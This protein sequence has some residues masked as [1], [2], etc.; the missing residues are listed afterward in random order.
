MQLLLRARCH[1]GPRSLREDRAARAAGG[2]RSPNSEAGPTG[3]PPCCS[4][5]PAPAQES[6]SFHT[7]AAASRLQKAR[8]EPALRA[9][10]G[11]PHPPVPG[12][13]RSWLCLTH[14]SPLASGLL[15]PPTLLGGARLWGPPPTLQVALDQRPRVCTECCLRAR[16][17][18]R[19]GRGEGVCSRPR[20]GTVEAGRPPGTQTLCPRAECRLHGRSRRRGRGDVRLPARPACCRGSGVFK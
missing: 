16:P 4:L 13:G 17:A 9:R 2:R 15:V 1:S 14:L 3:A 10:A 19:D 18:R 12:S 20:A 6:T 8:G 7:E 5:R 11:L